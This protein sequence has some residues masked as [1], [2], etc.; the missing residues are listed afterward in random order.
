MGC[1]N[2]LNMVTFEVDIVLVHSLLG[3]I[4][5]LIILNYVGTILI[6]DICYS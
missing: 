3:V 2:L 4:F 1:Y 5:S 6:Y